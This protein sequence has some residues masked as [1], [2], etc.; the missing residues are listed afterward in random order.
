VGVSL[1]VVGEPDKALGYFQQLETS[2]INLGYIMALHDMGRAEEFERL[3]AEL[4]LQEDA[5][6]ESIARVY[7]WTGD[8]DSAFAWLERAL[9]LDARWINRIDTDLYDKIKSD[10]RWA[11]LQARYRAKDDYVDWK[12]VTFNPLLPAEVRER[13]AAAGDAGV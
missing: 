7:A 8:A 2:G 10:P 3:F 1:L 12:S 6:A 13:I 9:A 4:K 11:A 5:E